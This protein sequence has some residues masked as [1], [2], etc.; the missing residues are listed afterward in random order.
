MTKQEK[1]AQIYHIFSPSAPVENVDLFFGRKKQINAVESAIYEKGQHVV[2]FGKRGAGKTSLANITGQIF[3]NVYTAKITC[4]RKDDYISL[5]DKMLQKIQYIETQTN[6]GFEKDIQNTLTSLV[7]PDKEFID[8]SDIENLFLETDNPI[9][10]IFDEFD[11]IKDETTRIMIA[12]TIKAFSDNIHFVTIF[13]IGIAENIKD[14]IG[15]HPSLERCIKQIHL[16]LMSNIEA[17]DLIKQSMDALE[18][19]ISKEITQKII[20]YSSGFPHYIHLLCK[21]IAV[22][23]V[24]NK[25]I[26]INENHFNNAVLLSI[27]NSDYTLKEAYTKAVKSAKN[28]NQFEDIIYACASAQTGDDDTYTT[29]IIL[30]EFNKLRNSETKEESIRYNLGMLCRADR[31]LILEKIGSS[32]N[33]KYRFRNPL[34]RAFVKLKLHVK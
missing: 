7:L 23:A 25:E 28:K 14:L 1:K 16:P 10:L 5:W 31:G 6:I 12:D 9:L 29:D 21:F 20:D 33:R 4:N 17:E 8:V 19:E 3:E 11:S 18:L 15:Y 30:Q 34:M 32:K 27:E 22:E 13:I 2:M 24:E 26:L